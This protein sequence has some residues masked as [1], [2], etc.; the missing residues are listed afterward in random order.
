MKKKLL[1]IAIAAIWAVSNC[2]ELNETKS[3]KITL[4]DPPVIIIPP[5]TLQLKNVTQVI[6]QDNA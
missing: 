1:F 6:I 5:G 3:F 2:V 4:G